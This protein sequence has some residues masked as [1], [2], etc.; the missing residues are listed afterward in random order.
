MLKRL[1]VLFVFLSFL[2]LSPI[3]GQLPEDSLNMHLV[4][5]LEMPLPVGI[6]DVQDSIVYVVGGSS[7]R[8]HDT[9]YFV[10]IS[11][12]HNPRIVNKFSRDSLD[13]GGMGV[14]GSTLCI[15]SYRKL[16][17]MD[18]S[19]IN[20]A[21]IVGS[22]GVDDGWRGY[23]GPLMS[24]RI[25]IGSELTTSGCRTYYANISEP[26]SPYVITSNEM[27]IC[28][29]KDTLLY[30]GWFGYPEPPDPVVDSMFI[31]PAYKVYSVSHLISD[32]SFIE[33]DSVWWE[34][35]GWDPEWWWTDSSTLV[36]GL[37]TRVLSVVAKADTEYVSIEF[38][39]AGTTLVFAKDC[40]GFLM[41]IADDIPNAM[42]E[43][44]YGNYLLVHGWWWVSDEEREFRKVVYDISSACSP[45]LVGYYPTSNIGYFTSV[46]GSLYVIYGEPPNKLRIIKVDSV[47][48]N[49]G[50][51]D[52]GVRD[53]VRVYPDPVFDGRFAYEGPAGYLYDV[54]GRVVREVR[55]GGYVD[56]SDLP[57]GVY[58]VKPKGMVRGKKVLVMR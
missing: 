22:L 53:S 35:F 13:W 16:Y 27:S 36:T 23:N 48:L 24:G 14:K 47:Y 37:Y 17:V 2:S 42:V 45:E 4:G 55:E 12:P 18:V 51:M 1:S 58:F 29:F 33:V 52:E 26:D 6:I 19:D 57:A 44:V 32:S 25:V 28:Y 5:E 43:D 40:G 38:E 56:V 41:E 50:Y 39:D 11:D 34:T 30:G 10:D 49:V 9:L 7:D 15:V 46:G 54:S 3:Y 8:L 20:S 21:A 31:F